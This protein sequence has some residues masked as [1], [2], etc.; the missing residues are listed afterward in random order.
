M[1]LDL[2]RHL[3]LN[4]CDNPTSIP[5]FQRILSEVAITDTDATNAIRY[6][7]GPLVTFTQNEGWYVWDGTIHVNDQEG[8]LGTQILETYA[9]GLAEVVSWARDIAKTSDRLRLTLPENEKKAKEIAAQIDAIAAYSKRLRQ[10]GTLKT[11]NGLLAQK[12]ARPN[13]Y[14]DADTDWIVFENGYVTDTATMTQY[15]P[16]DPTRPVSRKMAVPVGQGEPTRLLGYLRQTTTEDA[17]DLLQQSAGAAL[18]GSGAYK[19][20]PLIIGRK[21]TFKSVYLGTISKVLGDYASSLPQSA[22]LLRSNGFNFEQHKARGVRFLYLTELPHKALDETFIKAL[23]G[24]GDMVNTAAKGQDVVEWKP[25]CVLHVSG[26][27]PPKMN[28]ADEGITGRFVWINFTYHVP[29]DQQIPNLDR[30]LVQGEGGQ[31]LN[32][33]L[34]GA[35]RVLTQGRIIIPQSIQDDSSR[36]TIES[37]PV[38]QWL[39]EIMASGDVEVRKDTS[40]ARTAFWTESLA[41]QSYNAWAFDNGTT[42]RLNKSEWRDIL[43]TH[44]EIPRALQKARANSGYVLWGIVPVHRKAEHYEM[45]GAA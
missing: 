43:N 44:L 34:Q 3:T 29:L 32:W 24:G 22:I 16:P 20:V 12:F 10:A 1:I 2:V 19:V 35:R 27:V 42:E 14:F 38:L 40:L 41:W 39:S 11:C 8:T 18:L 25:Q 21:D 31:I 17:I 28:V 23:S 13:D 33:I 36:R 5:D 45:G 7:L 9:L 26:N 4:Y 15:L 6:V 37:S 30:E